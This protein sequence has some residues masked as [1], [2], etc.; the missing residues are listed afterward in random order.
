MTKKQEDTLFEIVDT[1]VLGKPA[2]IYTGKSKPKAEPVHPFPDYSK[3]AKAILDQQIEQDRSMMIALGIGNHSDSQVVLELLEDL[4]ILHA[5][6]AADYGSDQDPFANY[7]QTA[8]RWGIPGWQAALMRADE[9]IVRLANLAKSGKEP[10]NE[11]ME[12]A[13][14]D[15]SLIAAIAYAMWKRDQSAT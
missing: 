2:K 10:T 11:D 15:I 13:F 14:G 5:R 8:N 7:Q 1:K 6:K 9:K 3:K 4:K 12:E